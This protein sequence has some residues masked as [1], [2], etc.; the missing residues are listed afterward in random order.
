MLNSQEGIAKTFLGTSLTMAPEV[1]EGVPYGLKAD[2]WSL[3]VVFYQ[4]IYGRYP[5]SGINDHDIYEASKNK[6]GFAGINISPIAKDFIL[7]CLTFN[8]KDR[9]SWA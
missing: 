8:Q 5:Y 1:H 3:G 2:I 7:K 9:I 6:P 4:M